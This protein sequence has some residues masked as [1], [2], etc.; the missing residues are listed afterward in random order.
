MTQRAYKQTLP[1]QACFMM[2]QKRADTD[3]HASGER[4]GNVTHDVL[5]ERRAKTTKNISV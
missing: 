2:L 1:Q 5:W 4:H 3:W